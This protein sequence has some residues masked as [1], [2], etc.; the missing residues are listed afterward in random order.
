MPY[1][2]ICDVYFEIYYEHVNTPEHRARE[3]REVESARR[4][5]ER[6]K[7]AGGFLSKVATPVDALRED[8]ER[9]R[10]ALKNLLTF[11]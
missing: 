6:R 9:I 7:T 11:R 10:R 5:T 3:A 4:Y 2:G 8:V 1:C